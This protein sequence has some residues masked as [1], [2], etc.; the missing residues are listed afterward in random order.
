MSG[1]S[2]GEST[3]LRRKITGDWLG[4]PADRKSATQTIPSMTMVNRKASENTEPETY[5]R[6]DLT[7][8]DQ[9]CAQFLSAKDTI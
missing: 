1:S 9:Q 5:G 8:K 4:C 3:L 6:G 7:D 2:V